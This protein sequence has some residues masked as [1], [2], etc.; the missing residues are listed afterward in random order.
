M[1][2]EHPKNYLDKLLNKSQEK[3]KS[4]L[5]GGGSATESNHQDQHDEDPPDEIGVRHINCYEGYIPIHSMQRGTYKT[6][7]L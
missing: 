2:P 6:S 4:L 7:H 3:I 5:Q 1:A